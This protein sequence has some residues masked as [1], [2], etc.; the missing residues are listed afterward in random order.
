LHANV[1]IARN[2]KRSQQEATFSMQHP[3]H[4]GNG[5]DKRAGISYHQ[6]KIRPVQ[7]I[8]PPCGMYLH[9]PALPDQS[10]IEIRFDAFKHG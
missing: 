7:R 1:F 10:G 9:M 3:G 6:I 2:R 5:T 8:L 4:R